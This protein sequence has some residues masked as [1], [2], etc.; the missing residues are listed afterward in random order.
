MGYILGSG[1]NW[2]ILSN[3]IKQTTF[4]TFFFI[5]DSGPDCCSKNRGLH[6]IMCFYSAK[7]ERSCNSV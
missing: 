1:R 2:L 7:T 4:K 6:I 5:E 3:K